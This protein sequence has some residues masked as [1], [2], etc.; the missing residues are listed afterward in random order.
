MSWI[1]KAEQDDGDFVETAVI[2]A[3]LQHGFYDIEIEYSEAQE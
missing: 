1:I 2:D 3:L